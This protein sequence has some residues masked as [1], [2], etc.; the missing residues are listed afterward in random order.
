MRRGVF[1]TNQVVRSRGRSALFSVAVDLRC[2]GECWQMRRLIKTVSFLLRHPLNRTRKRA[3]LRRFLAWQIGSRLLP[4]AVA[5]PFVG[6]TRLLITRGM[7]GATGNVYCGLHEF[8]DMAFVL[9]VLRPGD[10]FIDV[11]ANIGSYTV[12]AAG[13]AG[14]DCV[15]FEPVPST[16]VHLLDNIRLNDIG[17][18]VTAHNL[19]VGSSAGVLSFTSSLDTQNHVLPKVRASCADASSVDVPAVALDE[20]IPPSGATT[21]VKID[22]EGFEGPVVDGAARTLESPSTLAVV[23]E[24]NGCG[25][26]Y[27]YEEMPLRERMLRWGYVAATYEPCGRELLVGNVRTGCSASNTLYVRDLGAARSRLKSSQSYRVHGTAI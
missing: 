26:L 4:A 9:H 20:I 1:S 8:E 17:S 11:G 2:G 25:A 19:A 22:V 15:S 7:T 16:F 18:R 3:A 13:A 24:V 6:S 21:V 10:L 14:A 5:V 12:M 23:V 27:G